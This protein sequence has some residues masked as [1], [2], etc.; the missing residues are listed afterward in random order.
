MDVFDCE[1]KAWISIQIIFSAQD[2]MLA[3][4][5]NSGD[6]PKQC[7][8]SLSQKPQALVLKWRQNPTFSINISTVIAPASINKVSIFNL[9]IE[10]SNMCHT[11]NFNPFLWM[12]KA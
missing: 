6:S 12:L 4:R 5:G 7:I 3:F 1:V 10:E 2:L 9:T 11:F 8:C